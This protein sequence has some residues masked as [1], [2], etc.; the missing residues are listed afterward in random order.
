VADSTTDAPSI[1]VR[2]ARAWAALTVIC[3]FMLALALIVV[4]YVAVLPEKY[5]DA[6][7]AVGESIVASLVLYVLVSLFLDPR[8]QLSQAHELAQYAI[9]EANAQFQERFQVSLPTAVYEASSVPKKDFRENFST[10]LEAST[11]YDHCGT[12]AHFASFRLAA[13]Q[14]NPRVTRLDQ[15]RL[16]ILD[17]RASDIIR[18]HCYLRLREGTNERLAEF[19]DTEVARLQEEIFTTLVALYDISDTVSTSIFLHANLPY[20]RC[21]MFDGGMFL[22]YYLGGSAYPETLEFATSTRPYGAYKSAMVL[23]RRF[24]TKTIQFGNSGPSTDLVRDETSLTEL[25]SN[26]GCTKSLDNLRANRDLRFAELTAKLA[27]SGID[28]SGLF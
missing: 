4:G 5:L 11:R 6:F 22:T 19:I 26:L 28:I 20:F 17:P 16:C 18:A 8:R 9:R 1:F 12:T 24:S 21:E 3:V 27:S 14:R 7:R 23:V 10:L 13:A 25:L 15:I 2:Y